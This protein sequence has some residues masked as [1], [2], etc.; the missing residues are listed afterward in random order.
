MSL[1]TSFPTFSC[2][3][4]FCHSS[5]FFSI[6]L[7][8]FLTLNNASSF[9]LTLRWLLCPNKKCFFLPRLKEEK[10]IAILANQHSGGMANNNNQLSSPE[11]SSWGPLHAAHCHQSHRQPSVREEARGRAVHCPVPGGIP[12]H[13]RGGTGSGGRWTW[14]ET[15][16]P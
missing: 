14:M 4:C 13:P 7:C 12:L 2:L 6:P 9:F 10:P 8:S 15:Y 11:A 16:A 5:L 1:Y 3:F